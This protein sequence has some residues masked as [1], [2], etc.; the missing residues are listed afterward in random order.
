MTLLR[1]Y[2]VCLHDYEG[3]EEFY[4]DMETPGGS[5]YIPD[6]AVELTSRRPISRQTYYRLTEEEAALIRQD[7]RVK[8]VDLTPEEAGIKFTLS[9]TQ[10]SS[11]WNKSKTINDQ[12]RNWGLLAST[13]STN[14]TG[15]GTDIT[16]TV[17]GSATWTPT[18]ANVDVVIADG[19]I[20][21]SHP[22]FDTRFVP[23]N[24][25]QDTPAVTGGAASTYSY[26][27][28]T[29]NFHATHVAGIAA[30]NTHGWARSANI[31]NISIIQVATSQLFDYVRYWHANKAVNGSTGRRN[32]TVLN[33]SFETAYAGGALQSASSI[34]SVTYR[35]TTYSGPFSQSTLQ[36]YGFVFNADGNFILPVQ[37]DV[38]TQDIWDTLAAGVIVVN[39]AGNTWQ[40]IDVPGGADYNNT[41][42]VGG[43]TI[44]YNRGS[45][46]AGMDGTYRSISVGGVSDKSAE[47][48][49]SISSSGP[50]VDIFAPAESIN[51]SWPIAENPYNDSNW[52]AYEPSLPVLDPRGSGY[53]MKLSGT[54]MAS[55]QVTG[56]V[57][58]L[59]ETNWTWTPAQALNHL[60]TNAVTGRIPTSAPSG[61]P[62]SHKASLAQYNLN[63][64]NN[65]Y[66]YLSSSPPPPPVAAAPVANFSAN[67]TS[68]AAP[69][70]VNFTDLSTNGPTSWAW[71][72]DN[73]GTTDYTTQNSSH[74]FSS[75][76]TY[77]VKLTASNSSGS[78]EEV[79]TSYIVVSSTLSTYTITP[80]TTTA[81]EGDVITWTITTTNV[82]DGTLLYWTN[83]GTTNGS[84]FSDPVIG[85]ATG[86][87]GFVTI[88]GNSGSFYKTLSNDLITEG[89]ETV[90]IQL[91]TNNYPTYTI[92]ATA[93]T[94]TV[95]DTSTPST[96]ITPL[97]L[98]NLT[99]AP[100]A[101]YQTGFGANS[102]PVPVP[103]R[104]INDLSEDT[105][106]YELVNKP[107]WVNIDLS[108]TSLSNQFFRKTLSN[109]DDI[110]TLANNNTANDGWIGNYWK[111]QGGF[112]R[113]Y[114]P[115]RTSSQLLDGRDDVVALNPSFSNIDLFGTTFVTN[116]NPFH[117]AWTRIIYSLYG[118]GT[119]TLQAISDAG[120]ECG[121]VGFY[122]A[123]GGG[124]YRLD[125]VRTPSAWLT[126]LSSRF[127]LLG[128]GAVT[129]DTT[130]V[131]TAFNSYWAQTVTN[132]YTTQE[133]FENWNTIPN[134]DFARGKLYRITQTRAVYRWLKDINFTLAP[135][136]NVTPGLY[137]VVVRTTNNSTLA[138]VDTEWQ[139]TVASSPPPVVA[140]P[141]ANF[142]ANFT[143]GISPLTVNFTDLSTNS[144][145]SWAWDIDNS[146]TTDYTTQNPS[147]TFLSSGTYSVKLT[148]SNSSGSDEEVKTNYIVVSTLPPVPP[149]TDV[150]TDLTAWVFD[151]NS[152]V[153]DFYSLETTSSSGYNVGLGR[154]TFEF[155][156]ISNN[157]FAENIDGHFAVV[158]R[159][160]PSAIPSGWVQGQG[161]IIGN[162]SEAP[163]PTV[164]PLPPGV[165]FDPNPAYPSTQVESF[166]NGVAIAPDT[167][168]YYAN[169]LL[170]NTSGANPILEDGIT[171]RFLVI[172]EI[173]A[174][175]SYTGYKIMQ[176][177]TVVYNQ[178]SIYDYNTFYDSSQT[179][180]LFGHVFETAGAQPWTV[181]ISNKVVTWSPLTILAQD[182]NAIQSAVADVLGLNQYGYGLPFIFSR[183]V[184][185][186]EKVKVSHW[187]SLLADI[188]MIQKH[189]TGSSSTFTTNTVN[190]LITSD[191]T[192]NY[193]NTATWLSDAAAGNASRRY[194]CAESEYYVDPVTGNT[195]NY[196][197]GTSTRTTVWGIQESNITHIV[198]VGFP[199]T[200]TMTYFFNLGSYITF[201]PYYL[202]AG[203]NSVDYEWFNFIN[204]LRSGDPAAPILR[205]DR[206]DSISHAP[207]S[208][209]TNVYNA[210]TS[211]SGIN[212]DISVFKS[213]NGKYLDFTVNYRNNDVASIIIDPSTRVWTL[214]V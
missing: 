140:A 125:L 128:G 124:L 197:N 9:V 45:A 33:C 84:D 46:L 192:T 2:S 200:D 120:D 111:F 63:G 37:N 19:H 79:K 93:A 3:L 60:T 167:S 161:I 116:G 16:P 49:L 96:P 169:T 149:A 38:I 18:G 114:S 155:D 106:S 25:Y 92:V 170:A 22:E 150:T 164:P 188:N 62:L 32:P 77:S 28:A 156:F 198:R 40:K 47:L 206:T 57:A 187:N 191:R 182:Y 94:V 4:N 147:H 195:N 51:S 168:L 13:T 196:T 34:S 202:G 136:S 35:G 193:L 165:P 53:I 101:T 41:C 194:I 146:G 31:Y 175:G 109:T 75:P 145:T 143:S 64:A 23:Y 126:P 179:N 158:L 117:A 157:Y 152:P 12:Q 42:E 172:S 107:S 104:T 138:S 132:D 190:Q 131:Q 39:A 174:T 115:F 17:S 183:Q 103:T 61:S 163:N 26:S 144:P 82:A 134:V 118:T 207:G 171:Y 214:G 166:W 112:V 59:L 71:D 189:I 186:A 27:D 55:P 89:P 203:L 181:T 54:S 80:N 72:I 24:W 20:L 148:A 76:G 95:A 133:Q 1:E 110:Q 137:T 129:K 73:S 7:S 154:Q 135:P 99:I 100:G 180:I 178:P 102:A 36:G 119:F 151:N 159:N 68:G 86:N 160:N 212:I 58:A 142:S 139:I 11:N 43:D 211:S 67:F 48:K 65:R 130:Q 108:P 205:Y 81:N 8:F 204:W 122:T 15:W 88:T 29:Y 10:T 83:A 105:Y 184:I 69:L 209:V 113:T 123:E 201:L 78:D 30:G 5:L 50:R 185:P 213:L 90:I 66:L 98:P 153:S 177:T 162:V 70:T 6:R 85:P 74:T 91:R 176:G 14:L 44:Y 173:R 141:V 87:T 210:T 199:T 21:S 52:Y 97:I 208:T 127:R 121:G 56:V